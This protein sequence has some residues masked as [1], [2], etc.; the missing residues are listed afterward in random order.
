MAGDVLDGDGESQFTKPCINANECDDLNLCTTGLCGA[1]GFCVFTFNTVG[2]DDGDEC[3]VGDRCFEAACAVGKEELECQ[4]G[5]PCTDEECVSWQGCVSTNNELVCDDGDPCTLGDQCLDGDC[6]AGTELMECNTAPDSDCAGDTAQT[7]GTPGECTSDGCDYPKVEKDCTEDADICLEG[8]CVEDPGPSLVLNGSMT[9][10]TAEDIETANQYKEITGDL[11]IT[12]N[13]P[14]QTALPFL[15]KIGGRLWV[16]DANKLVELTLPKLLSVGTS[17]EFEELALFERLS[18]AVLN[19]VGS[20]I[21]MN[22]LPKCYQLHLPALVSVGTDVHLTKVDAITNMLLNG[23]VDVPGDVVLTE[24]AGLKILNISQIATMGGSLV[25]DGNPELTTLH[26]ETL[27]LVGGELRIVS[28]PKILGLSFVNLETVGSASLSLSSG[29][30]RLQGLTALNSLELK[31]LEAVRGGLV[32]TL[33]P[34]IEEMGFDALSKVAE[35]HLSDNAALS[36]L[37]LPSLTTIDPCWAFVA[38]C[39]TTDLPSAG[40]LTVSNL[41]SL[42]LLQASALKVVTGG[43][44]VD[45]NNALTKVYFDEVEHFAS[46]ILEDNP[47]LK[48]SHFGGLISVGTPAESEQECLVITDNIA[49]EELGLGSLESVY[50][51]LVVRDNALK[52]GLSLANLVTAEKIEFAKNQSTHLD[53]SSLG[54]GELPAKLYIESNPMLE[55]VALHASLGETCWSA[56][57][58]NPAGVWGEITGNPLLPQC[59]IEIGLG[60]GSPG[61]CEGA[62][63]APCPFYISANRLDC[64]CLKEPELLVFCDDTEKCGGVLACDDQ[65]S[66]TQDLCSETAEC[67]SVPIEGVCDDADPCLENDSCVD[68]VCVAGPT[69][70]VCDD[71]NVCTDDACTTNEGCTTTSN[72]AECDD[73]SVCTLDE[74]CLNG[75]CA[76]GQESLN[77]DDGNSC[78]KDGCDANGGCFNEVDKNLLACDDGDVCTLNDQCT[79]GVCQPGNTP[80]PCDD[81]S[82]CTLDQCQKEFGCLHG[83]IEGDCDDGDPCSV[84]DF[85]SGGTCKTGPEVLDCSD[86][87]DSHCNGDKIYQYL[88]VG[89][90]AADIC[91]FVPTITDCTLTQ[92]VCED[93]LCILAPGDD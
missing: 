75:L 82:D 46:V 18:A 11:E 67:L 62:P 89:I 49:L 24:M 74:G 25:L 1:D 16:H 28:S 79:D 22:T 71:G 77:C 14:S 65:N 81:G 72:L 87:P 48:V 23:L 42:H 26:A 93:A 15:Q 85:C 60:C 32:L 4:D 54:M 64:S 78:T 27:T 39:D 51:V 59:G 66:C 55:H 20:N 9:I 69:V 91:L 21:R 5:N 17:L 56:D 63:S 37:S 61:P 73:G 53:L 90:C 47:M 40:W 45:Q 34:F 84:G 10:S 57:F 58:P 68:G 36:S 19:G 92:K 30:L 41:P 35:F 2:C 52:S 86:A 70:L 76:P 38:G 83:P 29:S 43:L 8:T 88:Q 13:V 50:G 80:N 12:E 44:H 31:S 7:Y 6:L 33:L 3:T